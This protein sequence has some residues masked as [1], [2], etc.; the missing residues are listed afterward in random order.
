MTQARSTPTCDLF[1]HG[2][3]PHMGLI[4]TWDSFPHGIHSHME[5][6]PTWDPFPYHISREASEVDAWWK[7]FAGFDPHGQSGIGVIPR[8]I[9]RWFHVDPG[10]S[11]VGLYPRFKGWR[12]QGRKGT[13]RLILACSRRNLLEERQMSF[14]RVVKKRT[15]FY[16]C[17]LSIW[18]TA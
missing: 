5:A 9:R 8:Q 14:P 6:I 18:S 17:W 13:I 3:L 7:S 1:P 10:W 12:F 16:V 15:C 2:S 4:S 11:P